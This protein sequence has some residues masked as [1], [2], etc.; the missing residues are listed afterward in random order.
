MIT[1]VLLLT[2]GVSVVTFTEPK[3][4]SKTS[5]ELF[6][7]ERLERDPNLPEKR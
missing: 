1:F 2:L 5:K 4:P 6:E 7:E 3:I